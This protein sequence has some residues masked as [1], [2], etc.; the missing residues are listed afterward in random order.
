MV[1]TANLCL[2]GNLATSVSPRH[3]SLPVWRSL[4]ASSRADGPALPRPKPHATFWHGETVLWQSARIE[5]GSLG[6]YLDRLNAARTHRQTGQ[7]RILPAA[8]ALFDA[9]LRTDQRFGVD[10]FVGHRRRRFVLA[11]GQVEFLDPFRRGFEAAAHHDVL[12]K[13]LIAMAHAANVE[14]HLGFELVERGLHVITNLDVHRALNF[15]VLPVALAVAAT[16]ALLEPGPVFRH[17]AGHEPERQPAVSDLGSELY[18]RLI[19][20]AQIDWDIGPH[21]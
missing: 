19:A 6:H 18:G 1:E 9:R 3:S 15:E 5:P 21:V 8:V 17:G 7:P 14:S 10:P 16:K 12:V 13:V 2:A 4:E 20:G 11:L